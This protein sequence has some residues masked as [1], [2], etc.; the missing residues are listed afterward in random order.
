MRMTSLSR[1]RGHEDRLDR[2]HPVLGLLEGDV[3]RA[4]EDVLGDLDAVREMRVLR[5]DLRADLGLGSCG[6][7]AGSA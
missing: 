3:R 5:G 2:V 7:P 1:Q 4:L 6:T